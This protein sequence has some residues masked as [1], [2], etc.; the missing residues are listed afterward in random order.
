[1]V[2]E[3][4]DIANVPGPAALGMV[5]A[6]ETMAA[7]VSSAKRPLL[8]VGSEILRDEFYV[9]IAIEIGKKGIPIAATGHSIKGFLQKGYTENVSIINLHELTNY[10]R[11]P[12]WQGLDGG[13]N[14]DV[15]IF[16]GIIYYYASQ[17]LSC[18]RNFC[19]KPLMRAISIDWYFHPN[20][21][22]SF[23]NIRPKDE[24]KYKEM[25]KKFVE[26]IRR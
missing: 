26:S 21:A 16:F 5:A 19:I 23:P 9:D 14:Y 6:P 1:M 24:D 3:P 18:I 10:L 12:E 25:L 20:A 11:D 8:V 13:G 22:M 15:V 7:V 17:M 4:F 2:C